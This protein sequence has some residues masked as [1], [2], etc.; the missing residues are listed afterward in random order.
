MSPHDAALSSRSLGPSDLISQD[1]HHIFRA[2]S[3]PPCVRRFRRSAR[4]TG[5]RSDELRVVSGCVHAARVR[6]R[7]AARGRGRG[8]ARSRAPCDGPHFSP[9]CALS[10]P[11][12]ATG[13]RSVTSDDDRL[14]CFYYTALESQIFSLHWVAPDLPA[15]RPAWIDHPAANP[16][17]RLKPKKLSHARAPGGGGGGGAGAPRKRLVPSEPE[18]AGGG[19]SGGECGGAGGAAAAAAAASPPLAKRARSDSAAAA[20]AAPPPLAKRARSD[21]VAPAGAAPPAP[22]P[23]PP[24]P[25]PVPHAP[26]PPTRAPPAGATATPTIGDLVIL[27]SPAHASPASGGPACA[28]PSPR[29]PHEL[30]RRA[31]DLPLVVKTGSTKQRVCESLALSLSLSRA[32]PLPH[33]AAASR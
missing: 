5:T 30:A 6:V 26:P 33:P 25:A 12:A 29:M 13:A 28:G 4:T 11:R 23:A 31:L 21:S 16:A 19:G 20:A 32:R 7:A 3:S 15:P 14:A 9:Q 27:M 22:A 1:H 2:E 24:A 18:A 10:R 8:T 17:R